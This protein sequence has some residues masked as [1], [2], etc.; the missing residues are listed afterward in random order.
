M[1]T[2]SIQ[3]LVLPAAVSGCSKWGADP[4]GIIFDACPQHLIVS[5]LL[6][7]HQM[8]C[9]SYYRLVSK[10]MYISSKLIPASGRGITL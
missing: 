7:V 6:C 9:L 2:I 1:N 8:V 10:K 4:H 3:A 5:P